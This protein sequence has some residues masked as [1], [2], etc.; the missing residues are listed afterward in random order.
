MN[1]PLISIIIPTYNEAAT[2]GILLRYLRQ[3]CHPNEIEILVIDAGSIDDT[4]AL[5]TANGAQA[6]ISPKKGRAAQM[7]FGSSL[8]KSNLLYFVH[9]DS[10]PPISFIKDILLA[11]QQG[12]SC[13]R[14]QTTFNTNRFI[15]KINA[16]FTRFDW[17]ICY[18]GDQTFFITKKLF[19]QVNGFNA[20]MLIM[21]EYDL[22]ERARQMG[23]YKIMK[24]KVLVSVRKYEG[25]SWWRVLLANRKAVALYKAGTSQQQIADTYKQM[26]G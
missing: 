6:M 18:G 22:T 10:F 3:N 26:L 2:I 8:A 5:A 24:G 11:L 9:A 15:F 12:F 19:E 17:F 16:F 4:L 20:G 7:N 25:R 21:E 1:N 23:Q 14:Y 13:G